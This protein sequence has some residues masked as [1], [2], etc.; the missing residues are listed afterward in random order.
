MAVSHFFIRRLHS[1]L[2]VIPVSAFLFVH[3]TVNFQ[4]VGGPEAFE[5][6]VGLMESL[7]FLPVLEW[8]LIFLPLL[9]HAIYGLYVAFQADYSNVIRYGFFRNI[10]FILQRITGFI[11]LIFVA[12]H[13]WETRVQMALGKELNFELMSDILSNTG[14]MIFYLVGVI[15]AIFHL[16]NGMWLFLITWGVTI[17]PRAQKI[18]SYVWGVLF[19]LLSIIAVSALFAF[20]NPEYVNYVTLG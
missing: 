12:W 3:L 20:T 15:A 19:I 5:E 18:S 4:A 17:G 2:G 9:F 6:A 14:M 11:T 7:P 1:L 10:V 16:S 13:V 8:V